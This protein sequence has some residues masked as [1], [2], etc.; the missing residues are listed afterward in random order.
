MQEFQIAMEKANKEPNLI[1]RML[2]YKEIYEIIEERIYKAI[3][4]TRYETK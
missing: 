1:K 3:R 2:I 4:D